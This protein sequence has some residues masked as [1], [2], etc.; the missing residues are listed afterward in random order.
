MLVF[1][2]T[3][4]TNFV[5]PDLI[6]IGLVAEGGCEFYAER[7]DY[8]S[9]ECSGFVRETVVPLLGRVPKAA[10]SRAELTGRVRQWFEALPERATI[11]FDFERDWLLLAEACLGSEHQALPA[12][13]GDKLHLDRFAIT[14]PLFEQ[15]QNRAYSPDWPPHHALADARALMA[16]YRVWRPFMEKIWRIK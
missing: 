1:L 13:V 9:S 15:A 4:F 11:V 7:T 16:G 14:H 3:E 10:C 12:N 2:D 6:S 8:C 5:R